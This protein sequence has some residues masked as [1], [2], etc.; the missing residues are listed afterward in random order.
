MCITDIL[1]IA[2][3]ANEAVELLKEKLQE[4]EDW[5]NILHIT[6]EDMTEEKILGSIISWW[7]LQVGVE[8]MKHINYDEQERTKSKVKKKKISKRY[9]NLYKNIG[10]REVRYY[11]HK[12][13]NY[14]GIDLRVI[15]E[16]KKRKLVSKKLLTLS[17][18]EIEILNKFGEG[19]NFVINCIIYQEEEGIHEGY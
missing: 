5:I 3:A 9:F 10:A 17:D 12:A 4:E 8:N 6:E 14:K 15:A 16:I 1:I 13:E 18:K 11:L 7:A 19:A 2:N